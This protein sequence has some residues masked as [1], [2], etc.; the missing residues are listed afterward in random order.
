MT[1][2]NLKRS[3][4]MIAVLALVN[5]LIVSTDSTL[6]HYTA[7]LILLCFLPGLAAVDLIFACSQPP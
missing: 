7:A 5:I 3:L 1:D 6:L 2:G 4:S